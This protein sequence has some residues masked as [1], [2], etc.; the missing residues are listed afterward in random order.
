[1]KKII[2]SRGSAFTLI[3]LLVVI[4]IIAILAALLLPALAKAKAKAAQ[5]KCVNNMKQTTLAF[6]MWVNDRDVNNLPARTPWGSGG[7]LP[8]GNDPWGGGNKPGVAWFEFTAVSNELASPAVLV[9][10]S[11]K[12]KRIASSWRIDDQSGGFTHANQR[13]NALSYVINMDCGTRNFGGGGT[14]SSV[15]FAQDRV[16]IGDRNIRYDTAASGCS[17][18]VN[19]VSTIR[20]TRSSAGW[21]VSTWTN[22]L[23][24]VKGNLGIVDGSLEPTVPSSFRETVSLADDN[25]S[26]HFLPPR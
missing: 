24:G 13:D 18:R 23:H 11:D 5:T 17:A 8:D 10:P 4:A 20:T 1:M 9:C 26:V 2:K 22:A 19:N 3:E 14:V 21:G 7:T 15:E 12:T 6:V 25:G 16:L